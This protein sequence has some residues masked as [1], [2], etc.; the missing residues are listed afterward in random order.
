VATSR[1]TNRFTTAVATT[2]AGLGL[3]LFSRVTKPRA[4]V[5]VTAL[6]SAA[7]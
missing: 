3:R 6:R 2:G 7:H 5:L 4:F 1:E